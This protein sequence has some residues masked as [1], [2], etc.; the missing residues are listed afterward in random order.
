MVDFG[1]L[2]E[3]YRWARDLPLSSTQGVLALK[4]SG[5]L[6]PVED[7]SRYESLQ[8][9]YSDTDRHDIGTYLKRFKAQVDLC[10]KHGVRILSRFDADYP[11][12]FGSDPPILYVKG[13]L[14]TLVEGYAV[15]GTREPTAF[16]VRVARGV[17][18]FLVSEQRSV[19][20]GL[21][22]G[23]DA[24]AHRA[25]IRAGGHTIAVLPNGLSTVYPSEHA[26]LAKEILDAGGALVS[27][28]EME[29]RT[30]VRSLLARNRIQ[31]GMSTM[32]VVCQT[33]EV[34]GSMATVRHAL[35]QRR[36]IVVPFP[37]GVHAWVPKSRG[38]L[39]LMQHPA[40]IVLRTRDDYPK[41]FLTS[42]EEESLTSEQWDRKI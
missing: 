7:A 22:R 12:R 11:M 34:G 8:H 29:D 30:S 25:A 4:L 38:L 26:G 19:V 10:E 23:C 36:R 14:E 41:M 33:D 42:A 16:G 17:S 15:I 24:E 18:E 31:S 5:S 6:Y 2:T 3:A 21:A 28:K 35:R 40:T 9:F 37:T 20:S 13:T 27:E 1:L 32:V 39:K